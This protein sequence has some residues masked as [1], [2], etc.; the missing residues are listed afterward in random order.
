MNAE[1]GRDLA[2]ADAGDARAVE[3]AEADLPHDVMSS[4]AHRGIDLEAEP[5]AAFFLTAASCSSSF[6]GAAFRGQTR[7]L[8]V[9]CCGW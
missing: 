6:N 7:N 5:A 2:D 1:F 3:L 9:C 4:P 8:M